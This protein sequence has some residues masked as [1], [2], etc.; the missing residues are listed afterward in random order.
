MSEGRILDAV[1]TKELGRKLLVDG[2]QVRFRLGGSSMFPYLMEGD[3][4]ITVRVPIEQLALGQVIVFEQNGRWIAHRL[5]AL[6]RTPEGSWMVAQGDSIVRPDKPIAEH[7]YVGIIVG[8]V[9]NGRS[10]EVAD[11]RH[12][13]Y[14]RLFVKLRPVPQALTRSFLKIYDRLKKKKVHRN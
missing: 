12:R 7:D 4:A 11:S 3:I 9:R 1:E 13:L 14:G 6:D 10:V 5:M 8:F 2:H